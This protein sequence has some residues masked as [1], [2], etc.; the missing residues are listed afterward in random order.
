MWYTTVR[1]S[2][3]TTSTP[4]INGIMGGEEPCRDRSLKANRGSLAKRGGGPRRWRARGVRRT[5]TSGGRVWRWNCPETLRC[6]RRRR[7]G[8]WAFTSRPCAD[9]DSAGPPK[10]SPWRTSRTRGVP[11]LFPPRVRAE[12]KA[13][14]CELP[15]ERGLPLSRFSAAD[16]RQVLLS[17]EIVEAISPSTVWRYLAADALR[18]W[19]HHCWIFPRDPDF[20]R[21]AGRV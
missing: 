17:E 11:R 9:G 1:V 16:I 8:G 3:P 2:S 12:V 14:A 6:H 10:D 13:I 5:N 18:P 4:R 15:A 20:G 7:P 21:K 19:R